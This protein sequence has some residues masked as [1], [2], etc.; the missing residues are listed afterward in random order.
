MKQHVRRVAAAAIVLTGIVRSGAEQLTPVDFSFKMPIAFSGYA[1]TETLTNFP[2]LVRLN[3][4]IPGFTYDGFAAEGTDLRFADGADTVLAHEIDT[5]NTNGTSLV[6]IRMP[7]LTSSTRIQ[8]YWGAGL[9]RHAD[10]QT[11]GNVWNAAAYAGVRHLN[12]DGDTLADA[13]ANNLDGSN[14]IR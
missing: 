14:R 7:E 12:E 5:W 10:S 4:A 1:G 11:D 9:P 8:S 3:T 6:W 2:V 13:T